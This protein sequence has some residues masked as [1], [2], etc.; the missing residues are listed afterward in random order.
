MILENNKA[1]VAAEMAA[2]E[3]YGRLVA[4]LSARSR[5]VA[6]AEDALSDAFRSALETWPASGV[7]DSPEAWL[8]TVARRRMVDGI[9]RLKTRE[10]AIDDLK[11]AAEE[12]EAMIEQ[13]LFP[14]DR[15]K[16]LFVCA[17][18]SIDASA[19]T[20]LMLQSVL[21]LDAGRIASAFLVSPDAMAKRLVRAKA[22]IKEAGIRFETPEPDQLAERLDYVL[23]A[24]Y[25][26]FGL[27]WDDADGTG[28]SGR[29]FVGEAMWLARLLTDLMPQ[30]PEALGLLALMLYCQSRQ[31]ARRDA[32]GSYVPLSRQEA[33]LWDHTQIQEA[34]IS[35]RQA[36]AFNRLG[37]FQLEAAI[38]S[39]HTQRAYGGVTPWPQIV[40]IYEILTSHYP[41]IGALTG[42][43]AALVEAGRA[44][45]A[46]E[47]LSA[48]MPV[49]VACYQPFWAVS[50]RA[51]WKLARQEEAQAAYQ[52]AIGLSFDPAVRAFLEQEA[53]T[54]F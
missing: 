46:L 10:T 38:Q 49:R 22:K 31:Q 9:R 48:I 40:L 29:E 25:A 44:E 12:A 18:P 21:G 17:H 53:R 20:A 27:G 13:R 5:D 43:A 32:Q 16:L 14:D 2:R 8:L 28:V 33:A 15:L 37:R 36:A 51:L 30:E 7:P 26:I 23:E 35:L 45:E 50:A 4:Y 47:V 41:T 19:R 34:E 52:R 24:V 1:I 3:A 6:S 42:H 54:N 39:A 11:L